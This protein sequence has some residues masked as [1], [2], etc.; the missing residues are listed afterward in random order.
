MPYAHRQTVILTNLFQTGDDD[1]HLKDGRT[2][3]K[4]YDNMQWYISIYNE[5]LQCKTF[6]QCKKN[7]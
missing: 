3:Y 7:W 2:K 1:H 4:E 5:E 6:V